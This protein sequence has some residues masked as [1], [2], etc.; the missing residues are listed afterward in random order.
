[1]ASKKLNKVANAY[2]VASDMDKN[3]GS[4]LKSPRSDSLNGSDTPSKK[5][6]ASKNL[7][8]DEPGEGMTTITYDMRKGSK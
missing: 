2:M 7:D 1:M 6:K 4:A 3:N 8:F 5:K